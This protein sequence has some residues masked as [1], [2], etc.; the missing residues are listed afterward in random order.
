VVPMDCTVPEA[1]RAMGPIDPGVAGVI[2]AKSDIKE[3]SFA[4]SCGE[5][6]D[7]NGTREGLAANLKLVRPWST[8]LTIVGTDG[9]A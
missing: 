1:I 6:A 3:D 2:G 8:L 4:A 7:S 9:L 5:R